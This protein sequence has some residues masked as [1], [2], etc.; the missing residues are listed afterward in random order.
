M[1][2]EYKGMFLLCVGIITIIFV[3]PL[4]SAWILD[5]VISLTKAHPKPAKYTLITMFIIIDG[6]SWLKNTRYKL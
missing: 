2:G 5:K 4:L 6:S 1:H 3:L